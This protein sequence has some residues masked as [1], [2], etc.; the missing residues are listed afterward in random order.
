MG[1]VHVQE[2]AAEVE[3]DREK[4]YLL[5]MRW[6][7]G[8]GDRR[9]APQ[10]AKPDSAPLSRAGERNDECRAGTLVRRR[11]QPPSCP[12]PIERLMRMA[13]RATRARAVEALRKLS[14]T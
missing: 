3:S 7:R 14:A 8:H 2:R 4:S 11:P 6:S 1:A 5:V 13:G 12:S 10:E 9:R